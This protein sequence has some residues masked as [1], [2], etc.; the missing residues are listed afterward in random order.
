MSTRANIVVTVGQSRVFIYR[1][2]D[3]YPA[4]MGA[5]ILAKLRATA[6]NPGCYPSAQRAA[7]EF[8]RALLTEYYDK[9]PYET[10]PKAVYELTSDLHGDIEHAYFVRFGEK[11]AV[12][13]RHAARPARS[14]AE[15]DEWSGK[16]A[17]LSLDEFAQVVNQDR[18][19]CNARI[20]Q[21]K[22]EQPAAYADCDEYAMVEVAS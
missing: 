14:Q 18:R 9:Q 12:T 10:K 19:E 4:E 22:V 3:G 11:G 13:V 16:G 21:L 8:L 15:V 17:K 2:C 6:T 1:H 7:D 20:R 5:D